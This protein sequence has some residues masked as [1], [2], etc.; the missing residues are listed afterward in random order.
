ME[1]ELSIG[2]PEEVV[3][4]LGPVNYEIGFRERPFNEVFRRQPLLDSI[5]LEKM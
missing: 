2:L 3:H 5:E 4:L 1:V